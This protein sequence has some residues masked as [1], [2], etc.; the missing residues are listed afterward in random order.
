MSIEQTIAT[1]HE[2]FLPAMEAK[3]RRRAGKVGRPNVRAYIDYLK[4]EVAEL[5]AALS[6]EGLPEV[7]A[8]AVDVANFALLVYKKAR[9]HA[10][11]LDKQ[12]D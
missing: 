9:E 1:L 5:E 12:Q 7:M 3:L 2:R 11:E 4:I 6:H 8:E 10:E